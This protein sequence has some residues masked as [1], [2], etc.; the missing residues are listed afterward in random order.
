MMATP[1]KASYRPGVP[2][3]DR[4]DSLRPSRIL[5]L[6]LGMMGA[7]GASGQMA[8]FQSADFDLLT[9]L[10][11]EVEALGWNGRPIGALIRGAR[12]ADVVYCWSISDHAFVASLVA[13]RLV[14]VVGGYE[15]A[16]LPECNYGNMLRWRQRFF[17][18][19]VWRKA[20]ALLYVDPSLMDEA[21]TA[22]GSA[23]R[24]HYLPTG[25]DADY[26]TP[27]GG[28]RKRA[29]LTVGVAPNDDNLRRK[30]IDLF[31]EAAE[32]MPDVEFHL[33]GELP[34]NYPAGSNVTVHGWVER[35]T[36]R[37]L[38]RTSAVYAQLSIHEGLP[39]ALCEAMLCGCVPVGTAVN[40]IPRAVGDTGFL[41]PRRVEMVVDG[42]RQALAHPE[43]GPRAR[44]HIANEFPL[45]RRADGLRAILGGIAAGS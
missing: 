40:G 31:L 42:I 14:C 17:T 6:Y 29:V 25:Y 10:G 16:A 18:R 12:R 33:A 23:G 34:P 41:V 37:E 32:R 45:S 4:S 19:H 9:S 24:G 7:V 8:S 38:Y 15:F 3:S 2:R 13:R 20:D 36:L 27:A 22:F 44:G 43:L 11:F 26:W 35:D 30:G 21:T 39:N 1:A 28:V 5:F